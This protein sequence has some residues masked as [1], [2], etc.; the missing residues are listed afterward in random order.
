MTRRLVR[1]PGIA[2][3]FCVL[4]GGAWAALP[5]GSVVLYSDGRVEKLL[6]RE[7]GQLLWEDDHKRRYLRS[8][9]P[10]MPILERRDFLS[11]R[12]YVQT[13]RSGEPD[14]IGVRP[15][16]E[17]IEFSLVRQLVG[18]TPSIRTWEC[19]RQAAQRKKVLG[20]V[21]EVDPYYCERF[22]YH[23]KTWQRQFRESREFS[24]SHDLGL[25]VEM[26]R[27][28]RKMESKWRLVSVIAPE[29]ATYKRLSRK[30]RKLRGHK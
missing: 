26:H 7:D 11:G 20:E 27:K 6:S 17:R 25:I 21:R 30:V 9:N 13:L 28:T 22:V 18:G 29:K 5:V 19:T 24:Y 2:A 1:Y 23:R 8:N 10:I 15:S 14:S 4:S 16:G 12:G 3:L